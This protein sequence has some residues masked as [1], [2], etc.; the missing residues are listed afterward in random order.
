MTEDVQEYNPT[1]DRNGPLIVDVWPED[2]LWEGQRVRES[3]KVKPSNIVRIT[4][5][6]GELELMIAEFK[7]IP[8]T[9]AQCAAR[10]CLQVLQEW[11]ERV[12]SEDD[13]PY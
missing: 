10:S 6:P 9:F 11:N 13:L 8:T 5:R 4:G 3:D 2:S 7:R 12:I 1:T